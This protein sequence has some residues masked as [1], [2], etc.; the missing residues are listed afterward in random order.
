MRAFL[1]A[2]RRALQEPSGP[3]RYERFLIPG[4]DT[5]YVPVTREEPAR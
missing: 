5:I 1:R 3:V 4:M 2:I